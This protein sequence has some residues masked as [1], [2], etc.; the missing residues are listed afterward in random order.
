MTQAANIHLI[1]AKAH[2]E[3]LLQ[4]CDEGVTIKKHMV[5]RVIS[6]LAKAE[7]RDA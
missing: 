1:A 4:Y 2:L 6:A 7:A 5:E 3:V